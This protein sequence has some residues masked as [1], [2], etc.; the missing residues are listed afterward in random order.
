M[1]NLES[2]T[3]F[4]MMIKTAAFR[5]NLLEQQEKRCLKGAVKKVLLCKGIF[6]HNLIKPI[7][8]FP[9]NKL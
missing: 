8:F 5:L 9:K 6:S 7:Y 4:L 2:K 1:D 3:T